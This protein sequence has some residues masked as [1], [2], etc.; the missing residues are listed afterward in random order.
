M[1]MYI[2]DVQLAHILIMAVRSS[3]SMWFACRCSIVL[4]SDI[5][6]RWSI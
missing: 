2:G 5:S 6:H 4:G 3:V 1:V